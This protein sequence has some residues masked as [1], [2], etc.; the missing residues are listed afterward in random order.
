M[1]IT[2]AISLGFNKDYCTIGCEK[3]KPISCF[4]SNTK[5]PY[6][7]YKVRPSIMLSSS[8]LE[9]VKRLIDKGVEADYLR[10]R[11]AAYLLSSS[12]K[13]RNVR[14]IYYPGIEKVFPDCTYKSH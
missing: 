4:S 3:T 8:I 7:D 13:Q 2:S 9:D 1:S 12:D 10:S 14:A 6:E 5:Q 11:G